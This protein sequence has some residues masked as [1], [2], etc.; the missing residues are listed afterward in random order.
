MSAGAGARAP[1]LHDLSQLAQLHGLRMQAAARDCARRVREVE[2][3]ERAV[4]ARESSIDAWRQR[5]GALAAWAAG[6]G[7]PQ[8]ARLGAV[9]LARR[10][11]LAEQLE[12][13]EYALRDDR[14][15]LAGAR[16]RLA[17][18]QARWIRERLHEDEAKRRHR[19][20][21]ATVGLLRDEADAPE[22]AMPAPGSG[23]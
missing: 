6:D 13:E 5:L 10:R 12:R 2:S 14:R 18:A 1:A 11:H 16:E 4:A 19:R 20:A 23:R 8:L 17:H 7:V 3:A 22:A 15:E 21:A 9:V